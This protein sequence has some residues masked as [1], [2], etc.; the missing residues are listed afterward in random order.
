MRE[1]FSDPRF[2]LK[3]T[4]VIENDPVCVAAAQLER[5]IRLLAGA[6]NVWNWHNPGQTDRCTIPS[7]VH[8][9]KAQNNI[10]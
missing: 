1:M 9:G 8:W 5:Y 3:C 4:A 2:Q 6:A 7:S 10:N